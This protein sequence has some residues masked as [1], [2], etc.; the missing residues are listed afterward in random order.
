MF[1]A[2]TGSPVSRGVDYGK[3]LARLSLANRALVLDCAGRES[4]HM[5]VEQRRRNMKNLGL[6]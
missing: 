4:H 1:F 6:H 2:H 5:K 3:A